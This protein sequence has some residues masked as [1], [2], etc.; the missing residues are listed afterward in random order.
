MAVTKPPPMPRSPTATTA[1]PDFAAAAVC[2][3]PVEGAVPDVVF[4]VARILWGD[5]DRGGP[6]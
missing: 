6:V 4:A 5:V 3:F 1:Q 2:L